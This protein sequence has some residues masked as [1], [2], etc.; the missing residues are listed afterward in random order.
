MKTKSKSVHNFSFL[1]FRLLPVKI[2]LVTGSGVDVFKDYS[3]DDFFHMTGTLMCSK[4][5]KNRKQAKR[6]AYSI[7]NI[8]AVVINT[9]MHHSNFLLL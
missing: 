5:V 2:A 9:F 1:F 3:E 7:L 4:L 8:K 6:W